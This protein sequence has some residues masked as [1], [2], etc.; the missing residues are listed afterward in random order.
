MFSRIKTAALSALVGFGIL[1]AAPAAAEAASIS[2]GIGTGHHGGVVVDVRS[3]SRHW[4]PGWR[5]CT[6]RRALGKARAM[7][8]RHARVTRA[9]R[10]VIRVAGRTRGGRTAVVF[11][12]A[13]HCPVIRVR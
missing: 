11:A 1:A 2:F 6:P 7:G 10:N 12:R 5:A 3:G 13:P 8:I 4:G 9:N